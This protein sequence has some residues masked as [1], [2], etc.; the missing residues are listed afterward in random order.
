MCLFTTRNHTKPHENLKRPEPTT[1]KAK[2]ATRNHTKGF[3]PCGLYFVIYSGIFHTAIMAYH[4][5]ELNTKRKVKYTSRK[6]QSAK[7]HHTKGHKGHSKGLVA[8]W[9][10]FCHLI[11]ALPYRNYNILHERI[12]YHTKGKTTIRKAKKAKNHHTK[13]HKGHNKGL[14]AFWPWYRNLITALENRNFDIPHERI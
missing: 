3:W 10:W 11:A 13:D 5:K 6:A 4:T 7:N 14:V 9:P 1:R 2:K 8:F 12:K